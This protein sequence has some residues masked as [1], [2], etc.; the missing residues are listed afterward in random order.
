[1][2]HY[3]M[4]SLRTGMQLGQHDRLSR[5]VGSDLGLVRSDLGGVLV[6]F[7]HDYMFHGSI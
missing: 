2:Y 4:T 1:M 7:R 3:Y 5:V 6:S